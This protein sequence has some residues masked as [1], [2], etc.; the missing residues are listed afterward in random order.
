[1]IEFK[2]RS[3]MPPVNLSLSRPQPQ[4][5][6]PDL[7]ISIVV[8]VLN[9]AG[10]VR[11]L[12]LR[13]RKIAADVELVVADGMSTDSTVDLAKEHCDCLV[14]A[15]PNRAAQLNAGAQA[16]HGNVLWF[17]HADA[18][19]PPGAL[20]EIGKALQN[21]AVVGGFFRIRIPERNPVYRLTDSF[22]HYAGLLLRMRSGDHGFFCRR[23]IF[24]Q[25]GGFPEVNLMEDV[26]FFRRLR[27]AGRVIIVPKRIVVSPRRYQEI[28]PLR[29]SVAYGLI[30]I[31]YCFGVPLRLLERIYARYCCREAACSRARAVSY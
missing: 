22:G 3:S 4:F 27:R 11:K 18:E 31:L 26:G 7:R 16:T 17:L 20:A 21:P 30:A 9:E 12:L 28:G 15:K 25:I 13:L 10:L 1:M 29:L 14:Q 23:E 6:E 5:D 19:P 2:A 24:A 8:P